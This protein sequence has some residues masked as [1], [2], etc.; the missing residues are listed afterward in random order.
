MSMGQRMQFQET[1]KISYSFRCWQL[2]RGRKGWTFPIWHPGSGRVRY[3]KLPLYE[4]LL[5]QSANVY[6]AANVVPR[7]CENQLQ[8]SVLAAFVWAQSL[9]VSNLAA[10]LQES[11]I[12]SFAPLA[13]TAS[14]ER[15]CL[16][17]S[18]CSS[19]GQ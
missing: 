10:G 8:L 2:S 12:H 4:A 13:T 17:G 14:A 15:E 11:E 1:V 18:E 6:G 5:L 16:C 7:D 9:D 19:K 3:R